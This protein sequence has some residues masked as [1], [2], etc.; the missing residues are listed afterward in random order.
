MGA[1]FRGKAI[2]KKNVKNN[3]GGNKNKLK[4]DKKERSR[5]RRAKEIKRKVGRK[6]E[7]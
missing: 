6:E 4:G 3:G 5:K 1:G 7:I 2:R